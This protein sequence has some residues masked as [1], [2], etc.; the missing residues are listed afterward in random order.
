MPTKIADLTER[1]RVDFE[2]RWR[3][4]DQIVRLT[5]SA[6]RL[7]RKRSDLRVLQAMINSSRGRRE[8]AKSSVDFGIAFGELLVAL[9]TAM[10][11]GLPLKWCIVHDEYGRR[12]AVKHAKFDAFI[13]MQFAVENKMHE[14]SAFK[15]SSWLSKLVTILEDDLIH[16]KPTTQR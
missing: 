13:N 1:D 6:A 16:A 11:D 12:F 5:L 8:I 9:E 15:V 14:G 7:T 4:A 3:A 10:S 2:A